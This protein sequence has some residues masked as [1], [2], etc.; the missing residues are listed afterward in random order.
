MRIAFDIDGVL[1]D[2]DGAVAR[3]SEVLFARSERPADAA[4]TVPLDGRNG[5][6]P[7]GEGVA[8]TAPV[9]PSRERLW[10]HLRGI[11]NFWETLEEIHEGVVRRLWEAS[12]AQRWDVLFITQRPE[13]AGDTAQCQTHRWL[14]DRGFELPNVFLTKGSRGAIARSLHLDV[15]VDDRRENCIDVV[16]ESGA[17]AF[18]VWPERDP[19]TE[20][21]ARKLGITVVRSAHGCLDVLLAPRGSTPPSLAARM[22]GL[23]GIA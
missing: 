4:A 15:M 7:T 20:V 10:A 19:E 21:S 6:G 3:E 9:A 11:V 12:Q 16:A 8:L 2:F 17:R 5:T 22:R 14:R 18:L 13:S 23:F 1:A